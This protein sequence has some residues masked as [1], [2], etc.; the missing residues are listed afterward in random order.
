MYLTFLTA[1][2]ALVISIFAASSAPIESAAAPGQLGH[3]LRELWHRRVRFYLRMRRRPECRRFD[4]LSGRS[5]L[6]QTVNR[7]YHDCRLYLWLMMHT[8]A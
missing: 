5:G 6:R 8:V 2:S 3:R 7:F 4:R 1:A